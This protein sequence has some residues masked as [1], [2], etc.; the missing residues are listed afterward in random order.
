MISVLSPSSI[1]DGLGA[2]NPSALFLT[3]FQRLFRAFS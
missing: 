1:D 3:K 2:D